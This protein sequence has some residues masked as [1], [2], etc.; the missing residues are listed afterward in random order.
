MAQPGSILW[1]LQHE[2]RVTWRT[3][4]Q[5]RPAGKKRRRNV[6]APLIAVAVIL[7]AT[8]FVG[9]PIALELRDV[10]IAATPVLAFLIDAGLV[11]IFTLMLSQTLVM[12]VDA[13]YD[14]GDLDLLLSSPVP[15]RRILTVRALAM[16]VN[17]A[18]LFW[19]ISAPIALPMAI[20]GGHPNVLAVLV[21]IGAL[22]LIATAVGLVIAISLFSS[23][24]P[25]RTRTVAQ[26]IAAVAGA[27]FV[28]A[29]QI[30]GLII[31]DE[32]N[33]P[34]VGMFS[35]LLDRDSL[36]GPAMWPAEAVL[37][38]PLPLL[39]V[40]AFA[41]AVFALI[42]AWVGRRFASDAA[43]ASGADTARRRRG[44]EDA[45]FGGSIFRATLAK[46]MR[47][48][49]RDPGLISQVLLRVFYLVP[50]ALI[51][52]TDTGD[53]ADFMPALVAGA[54][55]L[56]AGQLA[57]SVAWI[58]ISAED[59]PQLLA[60]APVKMRAFWR[61][62]LA[63]SLIVPI[64][65]VLPLMVAFAF[66]DVTGA[67]V[68]ALAAV[69]SAWSATMINLWLQKPSKRSD[70]RRSWA[71]TLGA[72]LLELLTSMAIAAT[73][74]MAVA[75]LGAAWIP[76]VVAVSVLVLARRSEDAILERMSAA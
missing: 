47:M 52:L 49:F 28:L 24:G 50:L 20:V 16:A 17:P 41:V 54:A 21:V 75:G 72:N 14:R 8:L 70:Y 23:I 22:A 74:G 36:P 62:K 40:S 38:A 9:V 61:A 57:G 58:A 73:A 35:W 39:G 55:S 19:A 27:A 53:S 11:L 42:A 76:A 7:A 60:S 67:A 32:D 2:I 59:A 64:V 48:L 31:R 15:P 29:A 33:P 71:S 10:E 12:A 6:P 69:A 5:R 25:R 46:E 3:W 30:P 63:A 51:I 37:G 66:V 68:G 56:L 44:R 13:F 1:F 45:R 26:V 4:M 34:G 65:L 43:A 18:L